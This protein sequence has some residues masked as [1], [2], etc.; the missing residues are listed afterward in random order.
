M[1]TFIKAGYW[2]RAVKGYK[3]WLNLDDV[4]T[5]VASKQQS[6]ALQ[7]TGVTLLSTGWT[8]VGSFYEYDLPNSNITSNSIVDVIPDNADIQIVIDAAVLSKTVSSSGN[9]KLYAMNAPS[10]DIGVILNITK[11]L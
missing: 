3:G 6:G 10:G 5:S 9:L 4:I 11:I 1:P 8:L 2:E 7:V